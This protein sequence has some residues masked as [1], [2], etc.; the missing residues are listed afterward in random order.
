MTSDAM[1]SAQTPTQRTKKSEILTMINGLVQDKN[2]AI[3]RALKAEQRLETA[4]SKIF[5]LKLRLAQYPSPRRS[6]I[7][8][9]EPLPRCS[10]CKAIRYASFFCS[11]ECSYDHDA[12]PKSERTVCR[13]CVHGGGEFDCICRECGVEM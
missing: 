4:T 13:R 3:A 2:R 10:K 1:T 6:H 9:N 7:R 12:R 5:A 8:E 11:P